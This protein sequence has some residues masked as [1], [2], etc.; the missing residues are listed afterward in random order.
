MNEHLNIEQLTD[1]LHHAL[2]P[3][4]DAA[5]YTHISECVTCGAAYGR[6]AALSEALRAQA[7]ATER[8][9]PIGVLVTVRSR[10]V[11]EASRSRAWETVRSW[12][13]P[14][15]VIPAVAIAAVALY[16]GIP[17]FVANRQPTAI[18]AA[19]YLQ[20]HAEMNGTMP[21]ADATSA[22]PAS[23][24]GNDATTDESV[25]VMPAVM[26]ADDAP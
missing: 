19:Y 3:E 9:L 14:A 8:D 5:A 26:T 21:F 25:A 11:A 10:I 4:S 23:L 20:D 22:V 2:D 18:Q 17:R 24:T 6:E 1:Y 16:I 13:R 12:L 7:R 15:F